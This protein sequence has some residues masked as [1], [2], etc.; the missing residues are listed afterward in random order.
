MGLL[1]ATTN[2]LTV[3]TLTSVSTE[4]PTYVKE[5]LY[6][7]R[8]SYP[9]RFTAKSNCAIN[10]NLLAATHVTFAA[11]FNHNFTVTPTIALTAGTSSA[12]ANFTA[13]PAFA[14]VTNFNDCFIKPNT[15]VTDYQY[16]KL[17]V[18]AASNPYN[19]EIGEFF[20]GTYSSFTSAIKIRIDQSDGPEYWMAKQKTYYGQDWTSYF[21]YNEHFSLTLTNVNTSRSAV[22]EVA[23]FLKTV[24]QAGGRFV[25]VPNDSYP[26]VYYCTIDNLG[27][28]AT[29]QILKNN[30]VRDWKLEITTLTKGIS[31]LG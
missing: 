4:D 6:N 29:A 21:S 16:W 20:L 12:C 1:Y 26:F 15:G 25:L 31:L 17:N 5:N 2:L 28:Y 8:P 30:D 27:D 3:S 10:I 19:L 9:M 24:Q 23:L 18:T 14:V 11:I 13:S 7:R 22:D